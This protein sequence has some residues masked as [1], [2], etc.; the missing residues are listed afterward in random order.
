MDPQQVNHGPY[1]TD[2]PK[3]GWTASAF[4]QAIQPFVLQLQQLP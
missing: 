2:L 1:T 4:Q 3:D